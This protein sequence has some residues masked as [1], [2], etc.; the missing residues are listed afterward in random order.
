[1]LNISK[2]AVKFFTKYGSQDIKKLR[3]NATFKKDLGAV[4]TAV[5]KE[6]K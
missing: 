4:V 2:V 3:T 6:S 5:K 1:M